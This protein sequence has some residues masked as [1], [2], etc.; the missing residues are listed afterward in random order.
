[1]SLP[2]KQQQFLAQRRRLVRLWPRVG[3][4]A[5]ILFV[6]LVGWLFYRSPLLVNPYAVLDRLRDS[7]LERSTVL[8]MAGM[9][10]IISLCCLSVVAFLLVLTFTFI[11]RERQYLAIIEET[12]REK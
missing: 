6:G 8:L 10:P 12:T 7:T 3:I 2:E 5:A 11:A 1:M 9:L 4:P